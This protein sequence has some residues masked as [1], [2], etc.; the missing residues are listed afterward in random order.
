MSIAASE[1]VTAQRRGIVLAS[2]SPRRLELT[3]RIGF[4]PVV[5][6]SHVPEVRAP[7][8]TPHEY[9]RRLALLKAQDVA[10]KLEGDTDKPAWI[11]SADTIVVLEEQILEKPSDEA[12]ARRML[13]MLSGRW[14]TVVTTFCWL[15]RFAESQHRPL[16]GVHVVEARV[17]FRDLSPTT[18]E[19]YVATGEP[20]DKA[21]S[22]GIQDVGSTI[23]RAIE[24][25]YFCVVG[26]PV[27][28]VVEALDELGGLG[29]YPFVGA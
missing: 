17:L 16:H 19:R 15:N 21:G 1:I 13:S 8:E 22:Y 3:R 25:S 5:V 14:H 28:E 27:C 4:E 24:G 11:L 2:G 18:I 9:T 29:D 6:V 26:L 20:M 23:V 7:D 10:R 12:D